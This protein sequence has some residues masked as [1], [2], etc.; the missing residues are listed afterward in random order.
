MAKTKKIQEKQRLDERKAQINQEIEKR[1]ERLKEWKAQIAK[2]KDLLQFEERKIRELKSEIQGRY[3]EELRTN[4]I[5]KKYIR[6]D[7]EE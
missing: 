7:I 2:Y 5:L 3:S 6:E 1:R 4:P